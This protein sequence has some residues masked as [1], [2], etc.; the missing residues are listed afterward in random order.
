MSLLS[1]Y[2]N[3]P[4]YPTVTPLSTSV[5]TG[6]TSISIPNVYRSHLGRIGVLFLYRGP[7]TRSNNKHATEGIYLHRAN[8]YWEFH[9]SKWV[10]LNTMATVQRVSTNAQLSCFFATVCAHSKAD[11]FNI[12]WLLLHTNDAIT[13]SI[14]QSLANLC[15]PSV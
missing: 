2:W 5:C 15:A 4:W 7:R 12:V 1:V 10:S 13:I 8:I 9:S 3:A 14:Y 6:V 11:S